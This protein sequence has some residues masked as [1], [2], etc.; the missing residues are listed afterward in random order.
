MVKE[1]VVN[2]YPPNTGTLE[3]KQILIDIKG[4]IGRNKIIVK[5]FN[6]PLY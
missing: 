5:D 4:E 3:Y 2:I 1:S 6:N